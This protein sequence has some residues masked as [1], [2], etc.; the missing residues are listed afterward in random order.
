[1][2]KWIIAGV[3]TGVGVALDGSQTVVVLRVKVP[4]PLLAIQIAT[5]ALVVLA[6]VKAVGL[7]RID[8]A[9]H[10]RVLHLLTSLGV[11]NVRV[12]AVS[13]DAQAL[14]DHHL[15][16]PHVDQGGEV[17]EEVPESRDNKMRTLFISNHHLGQCQTISCSVAVRHYRTDMRI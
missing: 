6:T 9:L 4:Q 12:F 3:Q 1:M 11:T 10:E 13:F 2:K 17:D 14:V 15:E 7:V 8:P 5:V 16:G